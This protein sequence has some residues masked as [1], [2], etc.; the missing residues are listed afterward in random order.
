MQVERALGTDN[1]G[2]SFSLPLVNQGLTR[3][4]QS[5]LEETSLYK[6][7]LTSI[8]LDARNNDLSLIF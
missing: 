3:E 1:G 6:T 8:Y 4:M 5:K 7:F 2:E